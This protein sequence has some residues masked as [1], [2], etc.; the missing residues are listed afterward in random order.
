MSFQIETGVSQKAFK[1]VVYG[2]ESV[3]KSTFASQFPNALFIDTEGST[4]SMNVSRYPKPSS[5]QMLLDEVDEFTKTQ[6]QT[7]VIDS[8]DW[9]ERLCVENVCVSRGKKGV[10][11]F[12]YGNGYTYAEEEWGRFLNKL[13]DVVEVHHK[14]VVL[15]AHAIVRKFERP[16][17]SASFDRYELKL[18]KKT[19][20]KTAPL[21]KEWADMV[22]FA[23]FK[24]AITNTKTDKQGNTK[25]K[26]ANGQ[27]VMFTQHH[28]CWD[29]KNRYG[30]A[31]ELPFEYQQIKHIIE[32]VPSNQ[33]AAAYVQP[34][35]LAPPI[36]EPVAQPIPLAP[37]VET[38]Q[39]TSY[40]NTLTLTDNMNAQLYEVKPEQKPKVQL[41]PNIPKQLR[42]LME[43]DNVS[44][45]QLQKVV[46]MKG[47]MPANM[48]V[49][50][51]PI[52]FVNGWCIP[53]WTQIKNEIDLPF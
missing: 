4:S 22:L 49:S 7:L 9:A 35:P 18:G 44:E 26:A 5:W 46:I 1:V 14:N 6:Y 32:A 3:G 17:E 43:A 12:G 8:A 11:D 51:Y 30:L 50:A 15:T 20:N 24:V 37:P 29:A 53:F 33:Q 38:V 19:T 16:E 34:I 36:Q 27:R 52:D 47:Y 39:V 21:T 23:N 25:G 45:E 10:E 40:P 2:V 41:D 42:D 28:P 31:P 48:P 13:S